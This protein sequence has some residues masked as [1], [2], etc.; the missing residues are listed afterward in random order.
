MNIRNAAAAVLLVTLTF[1][2]ATTLCATLRAVPPDS[3]ALA[4]QWVAR[5][6]AT[7]QE[8]ASAADVDRLLE[9]YADDAVYEHPHANA[10]IE[11]KATMRAGISS[12]L[13]ETRTPK[14]RIT[15]TLSGDCFA[16]IEFTVDL[17][18]RQNEKCSRC[19]AVKS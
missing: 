2:L 4:G 15:Q 18:L 16:V 17:E 10:R 9:L 6:A 1:A 11:G 3:Q 8:H 7:M 14:L 19:T 5:L 12:H 13:G